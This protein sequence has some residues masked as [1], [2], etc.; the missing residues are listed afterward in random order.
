MQPEEIMALQELVRRV[1]ISDHLIRYAMSLVRVTRVND[2]TA[3]GFVR[4]AV[5][6]GAGPRA[7][8]FLV[9][10]GKA[11][12]ALDGRTAVTEE[13]IR[14]VAKPVLRHRVLLNFAAEAEGL[15]SDDIVDRILENVDPNK[16]EALADAK[17]PP[18]LGS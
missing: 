5:S 11:R 3:P 6:W 1:P 15:T 10:G 17:L 8:Q 9:I 12:A 18:V 14:Y 2:E 4:E 7:S 16:S 13:D